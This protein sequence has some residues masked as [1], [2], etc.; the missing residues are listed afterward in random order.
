MEKNNSDL[1]KWL[2]LIL[3][4]IVAYWGINN[5]ATV[6]SVINTV[7]DIIFPF[8]L[9]GALA[10]ILNI[11]M[12]FFERKFTRTEK[13]KKAKKKTKLK[14]ILAIILSVIVIIFILTLIITLIVPELVNIFNLLIDNIPYY[15]QEITKFAQ[16]YSQELPNINNFL[17]NLEV[18]NLKK[19]AIDQGIKLLTSSIS[20]ITNVFSGI[21]TFFIAIFF[22]MYI[23]IDKEKLKEQTKK[24]I[25][26]YLGEKRAEK[27]INVGRISN[28]IFRSFFTVQCLEATIL[29]V[30]CILGMIILRIP[31]AVPI[32]VLVGVTALIPVVGCFIGIIIG[33]ILILSINPIKVITFIIFVLILQQ[34]EGNVIYP[35]VVGSS[36]GLP[37]M[38]V[39]VAVSV[40]GSLGG[41]LGM[42]IGVPI[43]SIIYT[44]VKK[45]VNKKLN[46]VVE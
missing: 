12:S 28:N 16:N 20:V 42:L 46:K 27:I 24:L 21:A 35:R 14:R 22:A 10:Y 13:K 41:I 38:W 40:G 2:I 11:P 31:Y 23:L 33:A 29:G 9:G 5:L 7:I 44:L 43:A 19:E 15:V 36:V 26:A 6:G 39:L 34:V 30:L 25:K 32:G 17:Q 18:E 1:K 4:A 37:G 3:V 8:I 45:D